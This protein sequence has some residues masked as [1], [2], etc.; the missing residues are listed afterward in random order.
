MC[1]SAL[2]MDRGIDDVF[3]DEPRRRE[4]LLMTQKRLQGAAWSPQN[5]VASLCT[6]RGCYWGLST[7]S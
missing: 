3:W 2:D 4:G 1:V 7:C 5:I 6:G